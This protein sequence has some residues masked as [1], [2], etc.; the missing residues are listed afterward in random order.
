MTAALRVFG[1]PSSSN[2][3]KVLWMLHELN[4]PFKLTLASARLGPAS[5]HLCDQTG[6]QP[7]GVVNTDDYVQMCPTRQIPTLL[8]GD[9]AVWESHSILRYLAQKYEPELHLNDHQ[10]MAM[11]SPWLDW[12][13]ASGFNMGCNHDLVDQMARTPSSQRNYKL[14]ETAHA[15]YID[16]MQMVESRLAKTKAFLAGE[17]FTIADIPV[18]CE[19]SRWSC[20]METWARDAASGVAPPLPA[21]PAFPHLCNFFSKL[22]QRKAFSEGCFELERDHHGLQSAAGMQVPLFGSRE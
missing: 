15:G 12:V 17:R 9:F 19:L 14:V 6:G 7:F 2:T 8:D 13:L 20:G 1:R 22:Q 10:G 5:Q 18:G 3:Q 11:C 21:L 4:C 16:R